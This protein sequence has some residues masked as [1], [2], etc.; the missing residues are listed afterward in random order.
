MLDKIHNNVKKIIFL[1]F[2]PFIQLL[3]SVHLKP[4]H[5]TFIGFFINVIAAYMLIIDHLVLGGIIILLAGLFD[6]LDGHIARKTGQTSKFGAL[7]DS[8]IDRYSEFFIFLGLIILFYD[9]NEKIAIIVTF[10]TLCG[11]L[12]VSYIRARAEGLGME[13][14]VGFFQRPER[15]VGIALGCFLPFP[16][17]VYMIYFLSIMTH[18][19]VIQRIWH[20][21]KNSR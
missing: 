12:L 8:T 11:S 14:K 19:T 13:C 16:G 17:I 21:Y 18:L 10:V 2:R 3:T 20:V 9:K 4:N 5:I 6:M 15:V 7:L 1:I